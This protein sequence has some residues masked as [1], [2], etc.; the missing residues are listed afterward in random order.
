MVPLKA[1]SRLIEETS[2]RIDCSLRQ[3]DGATFMDGNGTEITFPVAA[4]MGGNGKLDGFECP[5]FSL[6]L[7]KGML[8]AFEGHGINCIQFSLGKQGRRR[9][10]DYIPVAFLLGKPAGSDG[11][12]IPVKN[13]IHFE[14]GLFIG[15]NLFM[16][17]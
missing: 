9:I 16:G 2:V 4:A 7:I 1:G 8:P 13:L 11:I 12:V 6:L 17:W 10:L 15:N 3:G 5:G 14:E